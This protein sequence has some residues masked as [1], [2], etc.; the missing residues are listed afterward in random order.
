MRMN[1]ASEML[2]ANFG[3]V[4][5]K[6]EITRGSLQSRLARKTGLEAIIRWRVRATGALH[7][8]TTDCGW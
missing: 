5:V 1:A 3:A 2:T 7:G 8:S 4:D 6:S